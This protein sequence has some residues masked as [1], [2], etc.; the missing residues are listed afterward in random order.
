M[1]RQSN[2]C[3]DCVPSDFFH[4]GQSTALHLFQPQR[5]LHR[6]LRAVLAIRGNRVRQCTAPLS[7]PASWQN[8]LLRVGICAICLHK[9]VM[10]NRH[11]FKLTDSLEDDGSHPS[12]NCTIGRHFQNL[13][14]TWHECCVVSIHINSIIQVAFCWA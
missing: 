10:V 6:V 7:T 11:H 3:Q 2:A 12:A 8:M 14:M 1:A 5:L 4:F 9:P 13:H